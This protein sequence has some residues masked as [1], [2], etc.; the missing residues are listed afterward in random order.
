MNQ[1]V[2]ESINSQSINQ[3]I[4]SSTNQAIWTPDGG[5]VFVGWKHEPYRLGLTYCPIRQ[6][7]I[8]RLIPYGLNLLILYVGNF[9]LRLIFVFN[10]DKVFTFN[11]VSMVNMYTLCNV[12]V[13]IDRTTSKHRYML[14]KEQGHEHSKFICI[15]ITF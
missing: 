2:T 12:W 14:Q 6:Q 5:I 3:S 13:T 4:K 7:V 1:S 15:L 10:I 9:D 11:F 8:F